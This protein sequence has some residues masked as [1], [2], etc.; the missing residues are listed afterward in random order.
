MTDVQDQPTTDVQPAD[1]AAERFTVKDMEEIYESLPL[2]VVRQNLSQIVERVAYT[3]QPVLI[4]KHSKARVA[5]VPLTAR[6]LAFNYSAGGGAGGGGGPP[7][8]RAGDIDFENAP[9]LAAAELD[10]KR[11]ELQAKAQAEDAAE[12]ERVRQVTSH[13]AFAAE[14][15]KVVLRMATEHALD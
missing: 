7:D 2:S 11:R 13:P 3:G 12:E 10:A 4:A 1:V 8:D 9:G 6:P 5:C 15:R 14:V